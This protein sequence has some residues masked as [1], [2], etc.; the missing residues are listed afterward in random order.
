MTG[1]SPESKEM[2]AAARVQ[3]KAISGEP[4]RKRMITLAQGYLEE[5]VYASNREMAYQPE[6]KTKVTSTADKR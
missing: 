6:L 5:G 4:E 3:A 2:T 1:A